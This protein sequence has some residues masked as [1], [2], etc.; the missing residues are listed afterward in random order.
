[1]NGKQ[2]GAITIL[3]AV[4]ALFGF[5]LAIGVVGPAMRSIDLRIVAIISTVAGFA[6]VVHGLRSRRHRPTE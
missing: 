2:K 4:A 6:V 3:A 1:M 5:A